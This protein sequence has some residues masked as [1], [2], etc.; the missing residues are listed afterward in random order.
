MRAAVAARSQLIRDPVGMSQTGRAIRST[1]ASVPM[2]CPFTWCAAMT[3]FD[4]GEGVA[5]ETNRPV[6]VGVRLTVEIEG[7]A[8][9]SSSTSGA[10]NISGFRYGGL[11]NNT[12][13][14]GF[15]GSIPA[16]S[17]AAADYRQWAPFRRLA[18]FMLP[19]G[20]DPRTTINWSGTGWFVAGVLVHVS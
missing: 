11:Y 13:P 12:A 18:T 16:V 7:W 2:G 6:P 20:A 19:P 17:L 14:N 1:D 5:R 8:V 9:S 10:L 3:A 4:F 15:T